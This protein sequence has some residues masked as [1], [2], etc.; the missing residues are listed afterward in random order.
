MTGCRHRTS[1]TTN[2]GG[3]EVSITNEVIGTPDYLYT[4]PP[5]HLLRTAHLKPQLIVRVGNVIQ[6]C[7]NCDLE[8]LPSR[9]VPQV[10]AVDI[11]FVTCELTATITTFAG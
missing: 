3:C 7:E 4:S 5:P 6:I 9:K 11:N 2:R 1:L 10:S 8:Y